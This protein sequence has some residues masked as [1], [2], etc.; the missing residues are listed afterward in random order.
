MKSSA[1]VVL[2]VAAVTAAM[3]MSSSASGD[4]VMIDEHNNI[5]TSVE[6][7]RGIGS[8]VVA[9][10]GNR[11]MANVLLSGWENKCAGHGESCLGIGISGCCKGYYCSWPSGSICLCVPKGDPCGAMHTCCDGLSCTGFFSGDCV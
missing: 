2:L 11:K 7:K 1:T 5:M 9:N 4:A 6:G 10:G 3:V 8:S